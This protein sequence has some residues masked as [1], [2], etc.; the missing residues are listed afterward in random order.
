MPST[1]MDVM[2][3]PQ[4]PHPSDP[5]RPTPGGISR[6]HLL[7]GSATATLAAA[8]T[9]LAPCLAR[10]ADEASDRFAMVTDTHQNLQAPERGDD[11]ARVFAHIADRDPSCVLH[12]GD[13]VDN[14]TKDQYLGYRS[15]VPDALSDRIHHVPGNHEVQWTVD[16]LEDFR[17]VF[18]ATRHSFEAGGLHVIG[19][20]DVACQEWDFTFGSDALD[21]LVGALEEAGTDKPIVVFSHF[22]ITNHWHY[23]FN[24]DDFL[25]AIADYPVRLLLAGHTHSESMLQANGFTQL[26]GAST[27]DD[28]GYYWFQRVTDD[29]GDRLEVSHVLVPADGEVEELE[30]TT[31]DLTDPGAGG[32]VGP[33]EASTEVDGTTVKLAISAPAAATDVYAR[34]WPQGAPTPSWTEFSSTTAGEWEA[35]VDASHLPP[36]LHRMALRT[37]NNDTGGGRYDQMEHFTL[38]SDEISVAWEHQLS[39]R[40]DGDLAINDAL[41][42]AASTGGD[43]TALQVS[44][45]AATPQ[46]SAEVGPM[47]HGA[48]FAAD[49]E[50]VVV[51]SVDHSLYGFATDSGRQAWARDLEVPV[52]SRI[53]SAEIDDEEHLLVVAGSTLHCLTTDGK[54]RWQT[55]LA[56]ISSGRIA[57]DGDRIYLGCGDGNTWALS[58][59]DGSTIWKRRCTTQTSVYGS[60]I[61]GPW[62]SQMS[63]LDDGG[64]IANTYTELYCLEPDTGE[65]RWSV[66]GFNR[67]CYTAPVV[68]ADGVLSINGS[69]G[70][71]AMHDS[72]TG[73]VSWSSEVLPISHRAGLVP[74]SDEDLYWMVSNTGAL[75]RIDLAAQE[76]TPVFQV[77]TACSASTAVLADGADGGPV[78]VAGA[79]DGTVRGIIGFS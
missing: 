26:V 75:V 50:L 72:A 8:S 55:D 65:V 36:G 40:I 64:L 66:D 59:D 11:L 2:M 70:T 58:P 22:P 37:V 78:I 49:G 30:V 12:C 74:T 63:F 17:E 45:D 16:G 1:T 23:V 21:W 71:I 41:V 38:P 6:R 3:L 79:K 56:G 5:A 62:A 51:G 77:T 42:V 47:S 57:F 32:D 9:G 24:N 33:Y 54:S 29:D 60:L 18:G 15:T 44:A 14:G 28:P 43:L 13:I 61:H 27:K 67:G 73:E 34:I 25:T 76:V 31:V 68:T 46:W 39:G 4:A 69:P 20:D 48:H 52:V 35:E 19:I 7:A 10:A 53:T